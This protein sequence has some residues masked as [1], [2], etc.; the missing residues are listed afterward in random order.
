MIT[1]ADLSENHVALAFLTDALFCSELETGDAPAG[2][3]LASA[4]RDA[5]RTHRGW[6]GCTRAVAA[7][8]ATTP[9]SAT[10]REEWCRQLAERALETSDLWAQ[11][12]RM[13]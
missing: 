10:R 13:E 4:I 8:F 5:L 3:Q 2:R 11:F 12:S 1:V 6:N 7:A 9:T